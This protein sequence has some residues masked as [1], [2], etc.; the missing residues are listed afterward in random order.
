M[1]TDAKIKALKPG[2]GPVKLSDGGGLHLLITPGGSKLWRLA[3]RFGGKQKTLALGVY[4][5]VTLADARS[6]R[7]T[8]KKMLAAGSDPGVIKKAQKFNPGSSFKAVAEELLAKHEREG[9]AAGT[10]EKAK[11]WK[12]LALPPIGRPPVA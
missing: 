4:P 6:K 1:L 5:S 9:R 10:R 8:A 11:G 3:Y 12:N 2:S 7:D